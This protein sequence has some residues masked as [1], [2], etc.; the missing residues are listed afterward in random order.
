[1]QFFLRNIMIYFKFDL[2]I[3]QK[4]TDEN[5]YVCYIDMRYVQWCNTLNIT[6]KW[7][8]LP[9]FALKL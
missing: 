6:K 7:N 8:R 3:L 1:M 2:T 4:Q 5:K 9:C